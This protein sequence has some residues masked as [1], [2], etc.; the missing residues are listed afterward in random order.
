MSGEPFPRPLPRPA[1]PAAAPPSAPV[2]R[3]GRGDGPI[4]PLPRHPQGLADVTVRLGDERLPLDDALA[5]I[6]ADGLV[7]LLDG[8]VVLERY[9]RGH[10]AG[11]THPLFSVTKSLVGLLA[12]T[13]LE[14]GALADHDLVEAWLPDL[15]GTAWA[16][17]TVRDLLDMRT[18][19]AYDEDYDDPTRG[20]EGYERRA[21]WAAEG[22][23]AGGVRPWLRT[24]AARGAH[25]GAFVY[26]SPA[27]DVLARVLEAA[28]GMRW[29]ALM[30]ARIWSRLGAAADLEVALDA[31]GWPLAGGGGAATLRDLARV[32]QLVLDR[33][34]DVVPAAFIDDLLAPPADARAAFARSEAAREMGMRR[35]A[36]RSQWWVPEPLPDGRGL[37][38]AAGIHGQELLVDASQRV[39]VARL[40]SWPTAWDA[41]LAL[42]GRRI[43]RAVVDALA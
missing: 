40:A 33:G 24:L 23:A 37:L 16:G 43:A 15:V 3:V 12:G 4:A 7:V 9:A 11:A 1:A 17:A 36:Y 25:G 2:A 42:D 26:Q 6:H 39:V 27:T 14:D 5:R 13:L 30:G 20:Y 19:V 41:A 29:D 35:G 22:D 31:G 28:G 21:R 38:L 34:R 32:G 18:A 8:Q 10:E